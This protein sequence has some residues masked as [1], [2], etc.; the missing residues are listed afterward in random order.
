[1]TTLTELKLA[2]GRTL[3]VHDGDV[4]RPA[5]TAFWHHGSPQTGALLTPLTNA[6]GPRSVR[7]L[8]FGRPSYG[9]AHRNAG[10]S[11]GSIA[12]DVAEVADL[13]GIG[14]FAVLGASGGG[15]HALACAALLRDRVIG[16]V[17]LAGIAPFTV[18][19]DWFAGM[20]ADGGL[21]AALSGRAARERFAET[22]EF[23]ETSFVDTDWAALAGA[24][25]S[26]GADAGRA[27]VD[28]PD[29]LVDDDLAFVTPWGFELEQVA[30]PVLLVQGERDRVVPA[31]HARAMLPQL[32]RG[33]LW[34]RPRDGHIAVLDASP[35][36]LDWLLEIESDRSGR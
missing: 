11:V 33:E 17:C 10:R 1:M 30:A 26:L 28:S 6:A 29:G 5:L 24:W 18:E 36:A 19:Y 16:A 14:R 22:D 35:V 13:L 27:G 15:P 21:R 25:S 9:G 34:I 23:D 2:D 8:S 12:S 7:L 3:V 32:M 31:S 4:D 20:A